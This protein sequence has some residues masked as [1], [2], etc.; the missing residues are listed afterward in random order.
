[1]II[2]KSDFESVE[3]DS[4]LHMQR[5]T[6]G[7]NLMK[8]QWEVRYQRLRLQ[9]TRQCLNREQEQPYPHTFQCLRQKKSFGGC[10]IIAMHLL[11]RQTIMKYHEVLFIIL[12]TSFAGL[13][14]VQSRFH[15]GK[16]LFFT[17]R[18]PP[19]YNLNKSMS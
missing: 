4:E 18:H 11:N 5:E 15:L 16:Y 7:Y 10:C 3:Y 8:T 6:R 1:M 17:Q 14:S 9:Q 19:I 2:F 12:H 13:V